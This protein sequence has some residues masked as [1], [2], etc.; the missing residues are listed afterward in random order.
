MLAFLPCADSWLALCMIAFH[1]GSAPQ[2]PDDAWCSYVRCK[3][4]LSV[5]VAVVYLGQV[6][7]SGVLVKQHGFW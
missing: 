6:R 7:V 2:V 5:P 3:P 4:R 1:A